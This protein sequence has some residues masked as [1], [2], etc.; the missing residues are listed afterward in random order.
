MKKDIQTER[1]IAVFRNYA[2]LG[3]SGC[4]SVLEVVCR[5][6][7]IC[8]D[9]TALDMIAVF[10]TLRLLELSGDTD[11]VRAVREIYFATA[12]KHIRLNEITLRIRRLADEL[13][14]DDRTVY[15]RLKKAR[16]LWRFLRSAE[17][18][19]TAG[20]RDLLTK[21]LK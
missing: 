1:E 13:H 6:R 19:Q 12:K 4:S 8:R 9:A 20:N 2:R 21:L 7:G 16:E 3:L 10:D 15:R 11:A 18:E 14:V 5:L 17:K